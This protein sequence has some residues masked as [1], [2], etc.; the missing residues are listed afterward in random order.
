[1]SFRHFLQ[2]HVGGCT[3]PL[4]WLG[5]T[6]INPSTAEADVEGEDD[7]TI[8]SLLRIAAHNEFEGLLVCNV[9]PFRATDPRALIAAIEAGVDVF[10]R[11]DNDDA[12]ATLAR[13]EAVVCAWGATPLKH[14][15]LDRR[16]SE[17]RALLLARKPVLHCF[18]RTKEG[19][20]RHPL[21]L[22]A[23]TKL[24]VFAIRDLGRG[25]A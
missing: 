2:R 5:V 22:P 15:A 8:R 7:A 3:S 4:R 17:V 25:A 16:A 11:K 9:S 6:M 20:P 21:Y 23:A 1:M 19:W 12:L 10:D 18:G 13:C 24:Q 14:P